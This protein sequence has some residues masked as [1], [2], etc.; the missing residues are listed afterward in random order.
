MIKYKLVDQD[1]YTRRG[2]E[3]ETYWLDGQEKIAVG[4]GNKMCSDDVVHY[5]DHPLLAVL[6]NPIH[7]NISNPRLIKIKIDKQFAHDGLKGGC[8]QTKYIQE[9]ILPR[10]TTEQRVT[11]AIKI[12]LKYYKDKEY[13]R[14]AS[15]WLDGIDRTAESAARAERAARAVWVD[16]AVARAGECAESA[17]ASAA[18]SAAESAVACAESAA[19]SAGE[20]A[21]SAAER[22]G[23]C[24]AAAAE[25]AAGCAASAEEINKLFITV[26]EQITFSR[27][28]HGRGDNS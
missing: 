11:F 20:C 18:E 17:A 25:R 19:E 26:I 6:F 28:P 3:G 15:D 9:I 22:A 2:K 23:E 4:G 21:E 8:K 5:Y 24:A 7:A 14:W 16:W 27:R 1:G 12:S 10:I 13:A